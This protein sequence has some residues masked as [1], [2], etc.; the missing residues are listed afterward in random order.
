MSERDFYG[1]EIKE[2]KLKDG[3]LAKMGDVIRWHCYDFDDFVTWTLTGIYYSDKIIYLG[4]GIDFG[5]GIGAEKS[6]D[7]VIE[8]S[9]E[10]DSDER[11]IEKICDVSEMARHIGRLSPPHSPL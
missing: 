1:R 2:L 11:G 3:S 6:I 4:G 10:N 9:E 5:Q 7:E 8:E